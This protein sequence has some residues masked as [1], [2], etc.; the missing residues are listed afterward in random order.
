MRSLRSAAVS[1]L[2]P[3][4][5]EASL[6][7]TSMRGVWK[8]DQKEYIM[9]IASIAAAHLAVWARNAAVVLADIPNPA[10]TQPPGTSGIVTILGWLKWGGFIAAGVGI[11]ISV[12]LWVIHSRRGDDDEGIAGV[13]KGLMAVI[14]VGAAFGLV[15]F[16]AGM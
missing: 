4:A 15:G 14:I 7:G 2:G 1:A 9:H 13:G 6:L 3:P 16:L 8:A 12:I 5:T 11:I 10:P